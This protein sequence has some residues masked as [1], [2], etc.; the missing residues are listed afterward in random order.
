[1]AENSK[2]EWTDSTWNPV[3]G[4]TKV[5]QG[6]KNCYAERTWKRLA[7]P[8]QPYAGRAFTDVRCH[9]ERLDQPLRWRRPRR[10]FVNS[11][12][13]VFHEDVPDSFI[14]QVFAVMALAPQHTFQVLTKRPG[15]MRVYSASAYRRVCAELEK[16]PRAKT[17]RLRDNR[18]VDGQVGPMN[19]RVW[20]LQNVWLGVSVEDQATADER[21]PLLIET[22][23]TVRWL[24][25]EPLLES[26]SLRWLPAWPENPPYTAENPLY[27]GGITDHLDGLRRLGWVVVGGESGQ[28]AR[29]M[30]LDWVRSIRN[31]C[32]TAGVPFFFKQA[33]INGRKVGTLEI[34]GRRWVEY[35]NAPCG[36]G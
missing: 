34:D 35:P 19:L 22:P 9:P 31:Q 12:S 17:S 6:C 33:I 10:V 24:S 14:D 29:P 11:I 7:A 32:Q 18:S 21:I 13:D 26:V 15:R 20:P 36:P 8:G 3:T 2:I 25:M 23:A 27:N 1:M 4:C 28:K 30:H 5:S 16:Y